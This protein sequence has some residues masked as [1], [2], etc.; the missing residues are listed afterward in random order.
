LAAD[1]LIFVF[2][3]ERPLVEVEPAEPEEPKQVP[4]AD[5]AIGGLPGQG[6]HDLRRAPLPERTA[7][8][9]AAG[10]RGPFRGADRSVVIVVVVVEPA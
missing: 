9:V 7:L 4:P 8:D 10:G 2:I 5:E 6:E 3:A 1:P